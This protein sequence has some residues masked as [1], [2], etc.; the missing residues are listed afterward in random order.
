MSKHEQKPCPRCGQLF[1]CK[2]GDVSHCQ[3]ADIK[4]NE[5][6]Y[7]FVSERYTDCLCINCLKD[8]E[9]QFRKEDF[10]NYKRV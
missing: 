2:V 6:A 3:C 5:A 4:F 8:I 9:Q 7:A 1:E 10:E